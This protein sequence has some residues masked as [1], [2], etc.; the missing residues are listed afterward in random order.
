MKALRALLAGALLF[1]ALPAH[2]ASAA[3]PEGSTIEISANGDAFLEMGGRRY[4]GPFR[5]TAESDG[6]AVVETTSLDAYLEGIREVPFVWDEEALAAQ[7][8]AARTYLA[9]TLAGVDKAQLVMSPDG[10]QLNGV[11]PTRTGVLRLVV[12]RM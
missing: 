9:W 11:A 1:L 2:P 6:V 7:V 12:S 4:R 10:R 3:R 5:V 8:V